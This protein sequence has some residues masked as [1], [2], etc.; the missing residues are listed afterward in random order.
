MASAGLD[1]GFQGVGILAEDQGVQGGLPADGAKTAGSVGGAHAGG[2]GDDPAP[3]TLQETLHRREACQVCHSPV[4]NHQVGFPGQDGLYQ[5]LDI[6]GEILVVGVRLT[7][8][9][10]PYLATSSPQKAPASPI[11]WG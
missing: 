6:L 11:W 3:Q 10:A 4:A 2:P 5:V 1:Q 9:S 8:I 7:M